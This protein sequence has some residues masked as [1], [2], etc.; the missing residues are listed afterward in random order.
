VCLEIGDRHK[1]R[2][3]GLFGGQDGKPGRYYIVKKDG[4][5]QKLRSKDTANLS[6]GDI[7][8]IKTPGGGGYGKPAEREK[9]KILE[10]ILDDKLSYK[11]CKIG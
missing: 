8:V 4:S 11:N 2:P 3:W 6:E 5:T 7:L 1:F 10:D 9:T